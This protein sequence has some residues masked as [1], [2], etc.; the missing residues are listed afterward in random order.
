MRL[1]VGAFFTIIVNGKTL[2][3]GDEFDVP[4]EAAVTWLSTGQRRSDSASQQLVE[5]D[6]CPGAAASR[7]SIRATLLYWLRPPRRWHLAGQRLCD[8]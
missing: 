1:R 4:D 7:P 2:I 3:G 8:P 5:Q 6:R